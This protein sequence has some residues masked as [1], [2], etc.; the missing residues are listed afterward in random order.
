M[1]SSNS[2]DSVSSRPRLPL[3]Y[4]SSSSDRLNWLIVIY[5]IAGAAAVVGVA[6]TILF[7]AS[8]SVALG[9][10]QDVYSGHSTRGVTNVIEILVWSVNG[11][12]SL[13]IMWAAWWCFL[14]KPAAART[15]EWGCIG[16]LLAWIISLVTLIFV[17]WTGPTWGQAKDTQFQLHFMIVFACIPRAVFD[18]AIPALLLSL[19]VNPASRMLFGSSQEKICF[20]T[21]PSKHGTTDTIGTSSES[22]VA[23][24]V[25]RGLYHVRNSGA[26][27]AMAIGAVGPGFLIA[28]SLFIKTAIP[29]TSA[30]RWY[31]SP[32]GTLHDFLAGACGLLLF[33]GGWAVLKQK[34]FGRLLILC[35]AAGTMLMLFYVWVGFQSSL[36]AMAD[37]L[38]RTVFANFRLL[39]ALTL[40]IGL[41]NCRAINGATPVENEPVN[42]DRTPAI[43]SGHG[44]SG[45]VA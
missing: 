38:T 4:G 10:F 42:L 33:A 39:A 32:Q 8:F 35:G 20:G 18:S 22:A 26:V 11:A 28:Y 6:G 19:A 36:Q 45:K 17:E 30:S 25:A 31:S 41:F 43:G 9:L 13:A 5:W 21:L 14:R 37:A 15:L 16:L 40:L 1:N 44:E 2:S 24:H 29:W 27:A 34:Q 12:S 23:T 3:N 7:G